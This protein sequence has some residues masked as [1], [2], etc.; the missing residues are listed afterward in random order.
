MT[1]RPDVAEVLGRHDLARVMK[2]V[3]EHLESNGLRT[4]GI[5]SLTD[6]TEAERR[7]FAKLL[8]K[9]PSAARR[10]SVSL[11][12]LDAALRA[13]SL[14]L[15]LIEAVE[16]VSGPLEDKVAT[17]T[18]TA[19][20]RDQVWGSARSHDAVARHSG[21]VAW[22]D[23]ARSSGL[24]SRVD[25]SGD[26]ATLGRAL[27]V[28]GRLPESGARLPVLAAEVLGDSHGL[29]PGMPEAT[30]VLS[31]LA[32]LR[33]E[34]YPSNAR[35][36]RALWGSFG[37]ACDDLSCDVLTFGLKPRGSPA[38][39]ACAAMTEAGEPMR[40]TL[41]ALLRSELR[42]QHRR[43]YV[44]ENPV[45]VSEAAD[46]LGRGGPVVCLDGVPNT[47]ACTL[48]DLLSHA[49]ATIF[50]HGDFDWGGVRIGNIVA[51]RLP[52]TPW[53][54]DVATYEDEIGRTGG[55]PE[56]SGT[57]VEASWDRRLTGSMRAHGRAVLEEH[58][59]TVLLSDLS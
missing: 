44:C 16:G 58:L 8:G 5:V 59:I 49:G 20:R 25:P 33:G 50:Y 9:K 46:R 10:L 52:G 35:S 53:R 31:A 47:A 14:S 17:R 37:V 55:L 56:L 32:F 18:A 7:A 45:V 4:T 15:S 19:E 13:S 36:R 11:P 26:L 42:F 40:L 1:F 43:V 22:M 6:A 34:A 12:D 51:G 2:R 23:K 3:R 21:L 24:V 57:P 27:A 41:R 54:F 39:G 28:L 38:A 29:D 48:L 30:L